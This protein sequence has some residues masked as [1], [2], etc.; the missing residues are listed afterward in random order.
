MGVDFLFLKI[1]ITLVVLVVLIYF[2]WLA[3]N[4]D[5]QTREKDSKGKEIAGI[6][7][8]G[9]TRPSLNFLALL[10]DFGIALDTSCPDKLCQQLYSG[11]YLK[12]NKL[13]SLQL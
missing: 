3:R 11:V 5:E 10:N 9:I 4:Q 8:S 2:A 6:R 13:V 12:P 7:R 1:Y